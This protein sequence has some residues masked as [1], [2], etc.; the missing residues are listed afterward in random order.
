MEINLSMILWMQQHHGPLRKRGSFLLLSLLLLQMLLLKIDLILMRKLFKL[1]K[2]IF[3]NNLVKYQQYLMAELHEL[4]Q[5]MTPMMTKL[6]RS[7]GGGMG[8]MGMGGMGGM[9]GLSP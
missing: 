9:G 5:A 2:V 3:F 4:Q 7:M 8:G 1:N 6:S